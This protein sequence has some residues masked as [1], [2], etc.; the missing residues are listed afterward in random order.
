M[1]IIQERTKSCN[2]STTLIRVILFL[3]LELKGIKRERQRRN[4]GKNECIFLS[5]FKEL[6]GV[7]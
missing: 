2:N 5:F 6:I 3:Y 1:D 7:E 4:F